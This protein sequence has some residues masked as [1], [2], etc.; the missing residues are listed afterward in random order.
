MSAL[1]PVARGPVEKRKPGRK[2]TGLNL[3][4]VTRLSVKETRKWFSHLELTP[5]TQ[6][7]RRLLKEILTVWNSWST[8]GWI[9]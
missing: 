9:T 7:A 3:F 6:I 5:V 1:A 8:W 4:Q 2:N